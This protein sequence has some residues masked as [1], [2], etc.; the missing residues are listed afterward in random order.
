MVAGKGE[1]GS[2]HDEWDQWKE[3]QQLLYKILPPQPAAAIRTARMDGVRV[4]DKVTQ[5]KRL[6]MPLSVYGTM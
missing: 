4:N 2:W 6:F 1:L 3:G 5:E